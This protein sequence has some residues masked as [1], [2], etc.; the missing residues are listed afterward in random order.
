MSPFAKLPPNNW[1]RKR[2]LYVVIYTSYV[3]STERTVRQPNSPG[4]GSHI[5]FTLTIRTAMDLSRFA[6]SHNPITRASLSQTK[7]TKRRR[8][9]SANLAEEKHKGF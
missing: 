3:R 6:T 8:R 2:R 5:C 4:G 9:R 1:V 7:K